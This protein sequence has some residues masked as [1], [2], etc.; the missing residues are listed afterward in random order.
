MD[1]LYQ[2]KS[3]DFSAATQM[4]KD[5]LFSEAEQRWCT[6]SAQKG[7]S[8]RKVDGEIY[9]SILYNL[10]I[11]K[12]Y[13]DSKLSLEKFS[14]IVGTNTTYLSNAVNRYFGCN[15]KQ[16][17]NRYRI[18]HAK[19]LMSEGGC[20]ITSLYRQCGFASQSVFYAAFTREVGM[21]PL[22]YRAQRRNPTQ[23]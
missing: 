19:W 5:K 20:P 13:L 4:Q 22:Q 14:S 12:V 18:G 16:L 17:V 21:P 8:A 7:L 1:A 11:G 15:L 6:L 9:K 23:A 10:E 3:N 2:M